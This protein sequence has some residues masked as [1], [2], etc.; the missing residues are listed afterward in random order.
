MLF[1]DH[2]HYHRKIDSTSECQNDLF[3]TQHLDGINDELNFR[4]N[5]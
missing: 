4:E 1:F 2:F 5:L 3:K